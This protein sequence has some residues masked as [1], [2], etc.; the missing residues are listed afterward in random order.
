MVQYA[1]IA[2]VVHSTSGGLMKTFGA[3]SGAIAFGLVVPFGLAGCGGAANVATNTTTQTSTSVVTVYSTVPATAESPAASSTAPTTTATT[4]PTT[5]SSA[6]K[7]SSDCTTPK[8]GIGVVPDVV[9]SNFADA[10]GALCEAGFT[11]IGYKTTNGKSVWNPWN[12]VVISQDP[13]AGTSTAKTAQI[14]LLLRKGD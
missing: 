9:Y 5:T 12:W 2:Q 14:A 1:G 4:A 11:D 3:A 8:S 10:T 7:A 13:P 6:A